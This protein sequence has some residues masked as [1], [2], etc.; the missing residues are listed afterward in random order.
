VTQYVCKA[1]PGF[2]KHARGCITRQQ[3]A[4]RPRS[5]RALRRAWHRGEQHPSALR[6]A[7][8]WWALEALR[9][10][11]SAADSERYAANMRARAALAEVPRG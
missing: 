9:C 11:P 7:A 4:L 5:A 8:L 2:P 3:L 6:R 10:Y 1:R